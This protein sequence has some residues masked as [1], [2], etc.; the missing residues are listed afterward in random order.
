MAPQ[1]QE[2]AKNLSGFASSVS[3]GTNGASQAAATELLADS[4]DEWLEAQPFATQLRELPP[5]GGTF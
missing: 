5:A 3:G 4:I 1:F 2:F